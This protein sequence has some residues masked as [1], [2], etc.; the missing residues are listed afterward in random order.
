MSE[1]FRRLHYGS[2]HNEPRWCDVAVCRRCFGATVLLDGSKHGSGLINNEH[3][4][5]L[6]TM[7]WREELHDLDGSTIRW[8]RLQGEDLSE[9]RFCIVPEGRGGFFGMPQW[10]GTESVDA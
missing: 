5:R 7:L 10:E 9:A 4:E 1:G 2:S 8:F 3:V 6:A